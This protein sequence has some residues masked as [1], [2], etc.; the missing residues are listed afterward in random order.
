MNKHGNPFPMALVDKDGLVVV[1]SAW[2]TGTVFRSTSGYP[3]GY[4]TTGWNMGTHMDWQPFQGTI[5]ANFN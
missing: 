1:F 4:H 3:V 2:G 5:M